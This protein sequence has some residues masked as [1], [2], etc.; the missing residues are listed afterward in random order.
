MKLDLIRNHWRDILTIATLLILIYSTFYSQPSTSMVTQQKLDQIAINTYS[1]K[2]FLTGTASCYIM[3]PKDINTYFSLNDS[4]SYYAEIYSIHN[5]GVTANNPWIKIVLSKELEYVDI[6]SIPEGLPPIK[7]EIA[8]D[9]KPVTVSWDTR[10]PP[11]GDVRIILL[12]DKKYSDLLKRTMRTFTF[13]SEQSSGYYMASLCN[14][15]D[16]FKGFQ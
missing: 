5:T 1:P 9:Q 13:G 4:N 12:Y 7:G 11:E 14:N 6:K 2:P 15:I 10:I 16:I 3:E 8:Y